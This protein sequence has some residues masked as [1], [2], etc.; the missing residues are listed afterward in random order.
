MQKL[1][2]MHGEYDEIG[3]LGIL[4]KLSSNTPKVIIL[5]QRLSGKYFSAHV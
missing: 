3:V 4:N 2:K 5:I 1:F